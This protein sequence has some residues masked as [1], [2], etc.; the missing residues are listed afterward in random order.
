[1]LDIQTERLIIILGSIL[2]A[3]L[4]FLLP[5]LVILRYKRQQEITRR[6]NSHLHLNEQQFKQNIEDMKGSK[7]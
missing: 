3:L 4:L 5:I 1:M 2:A 6:K 7:G